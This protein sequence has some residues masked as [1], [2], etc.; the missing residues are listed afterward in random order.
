MTEEQVR[1]A[2]PPDANASQNTPKATAKQDTKKKKR[3]QNER[4][5]VH[6]QVEEIFEE[7]QQLG[8][9][10]EDLTRKLREHTSERP[11]LSGGDID[12]AWDQA[13]AGEET[14]GGTA[15]TPGENVVEE[16]G[17]A[18]G[19]TYSDDESLDVEDKVAR[20]DEQP[21]ELDPASSLDYQERV[22]QEFSEPLPPETTPA[23]PPA[24]QAPGQPAK[25]PVKAHAKR[26]SS[27]KTARPRTHRRTSHTAA[28]RR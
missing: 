10:R 18:V 12:A 13:D 14:V 4:D 21:W 7:A 20:R 25:G 1:R 5:D 19:L 27:K 8:Y 11:V 3:R 6:K 23:V 26:R 24:K 17:A 22:R 28:S 15:P 9:G 16:E 2:H